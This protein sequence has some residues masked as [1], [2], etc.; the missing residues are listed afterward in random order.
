M[1]AFRK[2]SEKL[3]S[4][5]GAHLVLAP[6]SF[7][8]IF[9]NLSAY[10]DSFF[11]FSCYP[12]CA[13]C[14]TQW[15][16]ALYVAGSFPGGLLTK[17]FVKR[18]GLKWTGVVAMV[19]CGLSMLGSAWVLQHS[20]AWTVVLYSVFF[21]VAVG[22]N[23]SVS[24]QLVGGWAPDTFALFAA[25]M[26]SFPTTLSIIQNQLITA[27]VNPDNLKADAYVGH[28]T[29]FSQAEI[30]S[31]VPMTVIIYGAMTFVLQMVG[32]ILI[33]N[34]PEISSDDSII[35]DPDRNHSKNVEK[36]QHN[37]D[38]LTSNDKLHEL[39]DNVTRYG[40]NNENTTTNVTENYHSV[41]ST[42]EQ[43]GISAKN[44]SERKAATSYHNEHVPK[45]WKPSEAVRTPV[46]YALLF[47]G[48][49]MLYGL[50]LKSNY[51]KQFALLYI[52]D[53]KYLTLVGTLIPIIS[54]VSKI[55]FG[56][57]LD[58][59]FLSIK[60][61]MVLS[62]SLHIMLCSFWYF[63]P[64]VNAIL[65]LIL[66]LCLAITHSVYYLIMPTAAL[67]IFGPM[68]LSANYGLLLSKNLI[69]GI[70]PVLVGPLLDI[71]GWFWLF[72]SVSIIS[73]ISLTFV[74]FTNFS[75]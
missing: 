3:F 1:W 4:I 72:T 37:L 51:Y 31:R 46:F 45:S 20:V 57:S 70:T 35:R 52:N 64:Q 47:F 16:L 5:L 15:I 6:S 38:T 19:I 34:P 41:P 18:L 69:V 44:S 32:Y 67:R 36:G 43:N 40:L 71:L 7:L 75:I 48:T 68:H 63:A 2:K 26:T 30:L 24:Y 49:S 8:W 13:D 73:L 60:D 39:S 61:A 25:T 12:K 62:L 33:S 56:V 42:I 11:R 21:G 22:I 53:D 9:G 29:Y 23:F 27:Y 65:Y 50:V 66:I 58:K 54:T 59:G 74:V 14:D 55:I 28:R 10:M 17:I